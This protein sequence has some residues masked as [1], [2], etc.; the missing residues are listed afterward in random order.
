MLTSF[1]WTIVL[2]WCPL[3][4]SYPI[5]DH[6]TSHQL[7]KFVF[8]MR[9]SMKAAVSLADISTS[10]DF[11]GWKSA[12]CKWQQVIVFVIGLYFIYFVSI[13]FKL[14]IQFCSCKTYCEIINEMGIINPLNLF[15]IVKIRPLFVNGVIKKLKNIIHILIAFF[16]RRK[17]LFIIVTI[18]IGKWIYSVTWV[19]KHYVKKPKQLYMSWCLR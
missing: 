10:Q 11:I 15:W 12:E 16:S 14:Y 19:A 18:M 3:H 17:S 6:V 4:H 8:Y 1:H 13:I 5:M 9:R 7:V 2:H